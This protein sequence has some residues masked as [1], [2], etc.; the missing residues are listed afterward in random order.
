[1]ATLANIFNHFT[2]A[3]D[4][5]ADISRAR[6]SSETFKLRPLPNE[7][8]YFFAKRIDNSRV[9]KQVDPRS[10]V[11]DWKLVGGGGF[12]AISLIAMLLPSG[13]GLLAG[14]QIDSLTTQHQQLVS[15]RTR[16]EV[17]ESKLVS[18]ERLQSMASQQDFIDPAPGT[19][20]YLP[21]KNA[22]ARLNGR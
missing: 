20:I 13:Y 21:A 6:T 18:V 3:V 8:V 1:M 5:A 4:S 15:E 12:A 11:R 16:L 7:D 17:E 9:V 2:G 14:Y 22:S 10:H 19:T